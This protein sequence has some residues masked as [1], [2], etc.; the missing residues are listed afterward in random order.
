MGH[1][2]EYLLLDDVELV[3][4]DAG[5]L[6]FEESFGVCNFRSVEDPV[7]RFEID[8]GLS[9]GLWIQSMT[10]TSTRKMYIPTILH[11]EDTRRFAG[12][13]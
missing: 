12:G 9:E 1:A 5:G 10:G 6:R 7:D 13:D 11:P 4:G 3:L 2:A 8:D